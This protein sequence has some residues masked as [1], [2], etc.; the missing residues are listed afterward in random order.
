MSELHGFI[1][2]TPLFLTSLSFII[3]LC[4]GSFLNVVILRLPI[5]LE[6]GWKQECLDYLRCYTKTNGDNNSQLVLAKN[7]QP[8]NLMFPASSCPSC[9]VAI[10]PYHNIP[11]ISYLFLR[12]KCATC[13]ANISLRYPFVEGFS[14][15][16][17]VI[18][19]NHFGYSY[20][21]L[22][23]LLLTWS[24]IALSF[25]DIDQL[26]LP[27]SICLPML[28]LGL[29]LSLFSLY[30]DMHSSIIGAIVGYLSLWTI[31]K[32]FKFAT[33][34]EGMGYGDFKLLALLGA[35]LGWQYLP[36]IIL[37]SSLLGVVISMA[38][39]ILTKRK[40]N[41]PIP[42]GPYLASVGWL[43]LLWREDI[44]SFYINYIGLAV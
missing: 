6:N 22:F 38:I 11:I 15:I 24:L 36:L 43:V 32:L 13:K 19:T 40:H 2:S 29:F 30:T 34:K 42:F 44:N 20:E 3:G 9:N 23:A 14:G 21:M 5:M 41:I 39:I 35:W 26:L 17:S 1:Q 33:G 4:I 31:Y 10:K 25:I 37:L 16:A 12:G 18:V 28:W 8:V 27:D 7:L